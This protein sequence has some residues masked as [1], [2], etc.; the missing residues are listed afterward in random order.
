MKR[1]RSNQ[2]KRVLTLFGILFS[3]FR[4]Q[5]FASTGSLFTV[6]GVI[7]G[8][9]GTVVLQNNGTNT[10]STS[11]DGSFDFSTPLAAGSSYDVTILTQPTNQRM[12]A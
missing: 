3:L 8:L 7:S 4:A 2:S 10:I 12:R 9:T 6:G 11:T 1:F 5:A